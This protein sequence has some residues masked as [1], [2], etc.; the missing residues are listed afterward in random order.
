MCA[1]L[2]LSFNAKE[3]QKRDKGGWGG[4]THWNVWDGLT[5]QSGVIIFHLFFVLILL[6]SAARGERPKL[7]G[8]RFGRGPAGFLRG[9]LEVGHGGP[10]EKSS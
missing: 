4:V 6:R 7:A 2:L 8:A 5:A 1:W 10:E 9:V 3:D